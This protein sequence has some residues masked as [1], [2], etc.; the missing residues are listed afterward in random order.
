MSGFVKPSMGSLIMEDHSFSGLL[1]M[2]NLELNYENQLFVLV[3]KHTATCCLPILKEALNP[4]SLQPIV[5]M[6]GEGNKNLVSCEFIWRS[7][8]EGE[9]DRHALLLN[10]GGGMITDLGGFCASIYKRGIRFIHIPT[11]LL[12]MVDAAIGGKTGI[13]FQAVKNQVGTFGMPMAT[14]IY[15]GFLNTLNDKDKKAGIAEM[16]KHA[17]VADTDLWNEMQARD[18]DYFYR[19]ESL[20]RSAGIKLKIV[21]DDPEEKGVRKILNFGHTIGHAL[22]SFSLEHDAQPLLHGEAV[23]TGMI[24]ESL[25]SSRLLGLGIEQQQAISNTILKFFK[26]YFIPRQQFDHLINLMKQDKKN[27]SGKIGFSLLKDTG[28]A[29]WDIWVEEKL[30]REVLDQ[31]HQP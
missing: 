31:W 28:K 23:A 7:L 16:I 1:N 2:L 30:I 10:L 19:P 26:P 13:N 15:P 27:K 21:A 11:T 22:E 5:V 29:V 25:L 20:L 6:P 9:A 8:T 24:L 17:V 12:G 4:L 18:E 14:Y 3:D